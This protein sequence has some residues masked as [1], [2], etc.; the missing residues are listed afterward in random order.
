MPLTH[1]NSP[2]LTE[3]DA[4]LEALLAKMSADPAT[5]ATLAAML[6]KITSDPATQAT[7][8][9]ILAKLNASL[10]IT[11]PTGASTEATQVSVLTAIGLLATQATL[12]AVRV[13]LVPKTCKIAAISISG[14]GPVTVVAAVTSKRIKVVSL[15]MV[16]TGTLPTLTFKSNTTAL[17]TLGSGLLGSAVNQAI[18]P[19]HCLFGTAAGEALNITMTGTLPTS[20]GILTYFD[21]D[22]T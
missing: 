19:P 5:Q 16:I 11:L 1:P 17:F 4:D 10:S 22:A 7:L 20:T 8:A 21:D 14:A 18:A 2:M 9:A 3:I 15:F 12:E 6:A 13:L